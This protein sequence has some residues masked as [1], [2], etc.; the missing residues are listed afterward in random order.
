[1]CIV[2]FTNTMHVIHDLHLNTLIGLGEQRDGL[3]YFRDI[4]RIRALPT[5]GGSSYNLWHQ[6]LGHPSNKVVRSLPFSVV[7]SDKIK[8]VMCVIKPNILELLFLSVKVELVLD[9]KLYIVTCG[10]KII[11]PLHV[12]P[13]I[14]SLWLMITLELFGC[15]FFMTKLKF[16]RYFIL[17]FL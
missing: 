8:L 14:F 9:L 5:A 10:E 2:T 4:P 13:H 7:R 3:Y 17:S 6:R 12:V 15:F 16:L 1:M 11:L